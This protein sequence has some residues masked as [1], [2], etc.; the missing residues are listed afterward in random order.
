MR[1]RINGHSVL[2]VRNRI[3]SGEEL[4]AFS[5]DGTLKTIRMDDPLLTRERVER[6]FVNHSQYI[7]LRQDLEPYTILRRVG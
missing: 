5:P 7:I 1:E 4:E 6:D 3:E 2:E